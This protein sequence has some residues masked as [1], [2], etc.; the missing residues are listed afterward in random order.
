MKQHTSRRRPR[1]PLRGP[2]RFRTPLGRGRGIALWVARLSARRVEWLH[3]AVE[4][5]FRC[6]R[7][8]PALFLRSGVALVRRVDARLFSWLLQ[9]GFHFHERPKH[10]APSA[11]EL[12]SPA[13]AQRVERRFVMGGLRTVVA[14]QIL[15]SSAAPARWTLDARF[16]ER[17]T[18]R[19]L[20]LAA[21]SAG[22]R[23]VHRERHQLRVVRSEE[24][25]THVFERSRRSELGAPGRLP[26]TLARSLPA[27]TPPGK[28]E[29]SMPAAADPRLELT[30]P[31]S[32]MPPPLPFDI[33]RLTEQ[34]VTRLDRRVVAARERLGRI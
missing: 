8:V 23:E 11:R 28:S 22:L 26:L 1:R 10:P 29:A 7:S 16:E 20:R 31:R 12:P 15:R 32:P 3:A 5:A 25:R 21:A 4:R 14:S 2:H 13:L 33:E 18:S 9:P 17:R 6:R 27:G 19:V 30:A 24:L 34:V